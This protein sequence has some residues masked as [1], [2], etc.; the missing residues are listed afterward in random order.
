ML[1]TPW[2]FKS[3]RA[4][5]K[6]NTDNADPEGYYLD[7]LTFSLCGKYLVAKTKNDTVHVLQ[8]PQEMVNPKDQKQVGDTSSVPYVERSS[9]QVSRSSLQK[10]L[11]GYGLLPGAI[12]P[13]THLV[14]APKEVDDPNVLVLT[15]AGNDIK[16]KS[17]T[18]GTSENNRHLRLL[19]MPKSFNCR[20]SAISIK[21][22]ERLDDPVRIM[23]NKRPEEG[24][25]LSDG[26]EAQ[27]PTIVERE[28]TSI[29]QVE[30]LKRTC[31]G[32]C[33]SCSHFRS[34]VWSTKAS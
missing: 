23:M 27:F 24:Y 17:V 9:N 10:T 32:R 30:N 11:G 4:A 5:C 3:K 13:G 21:I 16:A 22:P 19:S 31:L 26:K 1:M 7:S 28:F 8:I 33:Y 12:L 34:A 2:D 18:Q 14:S 25:S 15:A 29:K 6:C 20:N